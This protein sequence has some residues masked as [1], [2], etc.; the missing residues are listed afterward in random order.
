M[1]GCDAGPS[2]WLKCCFFISNHLLRTRTVLACCPALQFSYARASA[3]PRG[4][5]GQPLSKR[6]RTARAL[7]VV[8]L[9]PKT[10][11]LA[12]SAQAAAAGDAQAAVALQAATAPQSRG[13]LTVWAV[14]EAGKDSVQLFVEKAV[15][16]RM[17]ACEIAA[18]R[19]R[20]ALPDVSRSGRGNAKQV[21]DVMEQHFMAA[22]SDL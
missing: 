1:R 3:M 9:Q 21:R 15:L 16:Q 13:A 20:A 6:N 19:W 7:R 10:D 8:V 4:P 18:E 5:S 12:E 11:V 22:V 2:C 14:A 17:A